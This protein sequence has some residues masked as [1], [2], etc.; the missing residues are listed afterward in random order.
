ML[1]NL[2]AK[3]MLADHWDGVVVFSS[4]QGFP[5]WERVLS[6]TLEGAGGIFVLGL[7]FGLHRIAHNTAERYVHGLC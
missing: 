1:L 5:V 3:P 7:A 4:Q 6:A 2:A